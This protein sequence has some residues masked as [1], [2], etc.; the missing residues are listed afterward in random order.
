MEFSD[1]KLNILQRGILQKVITLLIYAIGT[2]I[3]ASLIDWIDKQ[4]FISVI[5]EYHNNGKLSEKAVNVFSIVIESRGS[6][7]ILVII[8]IIVIYGILCFIFMRRTAQLN[9]SYSVVLDKVFEF[10]N[11]MESIDIFNPEERFEFIIK[12]KVPLYI[13]HSPIIGKEKEKVKVKFYAFAN[14]DYLCSADTIDKYTGKQVLCI[15]SNDYEYILKTYGNEKKSAYL[16]KISDLETTV[17]NFKG[18][19]SLLQQDMD[20][21]AKEK[22]NLEEKNRK[23]RHRLQTLPA[24]KGN[25]EKREYERIPFWMVAVP[26][27][28]RLI[29]EAKPG[30]QYTR[31]QIQ[32]AF[33]RELENFPE[34]KTAIQNLLQTSTK[35]A[36][37]TPFALD[38]W[39]MELIRAALGDLTRKDPGA[40]RKDGKHT[41]P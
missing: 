37:N 18:T 29:A 1:K 10:R 40:T 15:E 9:W 22:E 33:E 5:N 39:A 17:K 32:A 19:L 21:L 35:E 36:Q 4:W 31:P 20:T 14:Y 34:Q 6:I 27:V 25:T 8:S 7:A 23:L 41:A 13:A 2:S 38:G 12:S 30:L 24:R 3:L 28:N 16:S 11:A 26:L